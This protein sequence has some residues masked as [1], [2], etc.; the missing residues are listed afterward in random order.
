MY[1]L[2]VSVDTNIGFGTYTDWLP[3]QSMWWL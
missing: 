3:F 2:T 1:G